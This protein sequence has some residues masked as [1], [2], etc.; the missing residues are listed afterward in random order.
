[1]GARLSWFPVRHLVE[2]A[3]GRGVGS[4]WLDH[5]RELGF[6]AVEVHEL[7]LRSAVA[8]EDVEARLRGNQLELSMITAAPEYTQRTGQREQDALMQRLLEIAERLGCT[9]IRVTAGQAPANEPLGEVV[10]R[11]A[12]ALALHAEHADRHGVVLCLE[13][14]FRDRTWSQDA[15]DITFN[16]DIFLSLIS[17]LEGTPV[18]VNF[19]TAQPVFAR[20]DPVTLLAEVAGLVV[21][22]HAGERF[23]GQREHAVIGTGDVD[24]DGIFGLLAQNRFDGF[25]SVEDGSSG[26][27]GTRRAIAFLETRI[28][29]LAAPE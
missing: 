28:A 15:V 2:H 10:Q 9:R 5:A 25:L 13:N 24:W 8:V 20:T 16:R 3:E 29:T 14:H 27:E 6:D 21:N 11:A 23:W 26:D 19:D 4:R 22:V 18:R 7:Y 1:M 17:S 12:N